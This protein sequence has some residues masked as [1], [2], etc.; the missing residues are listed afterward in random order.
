MLQGPLNYFVAGATN[1]IDQYGCYG[2]L[3]DMRVQDSYKAKGVD[4]VRLKPRPVERG[5]PSY[6]ESARGH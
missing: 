4:D 1:L 5:K 2:I 6:R 3:Q